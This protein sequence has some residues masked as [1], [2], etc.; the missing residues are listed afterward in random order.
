MFISLATTA[1]WK[2]VT[3]YDVLPEDCRFAVGNNDVG[4][5]PGLHVLQH[6]GQVFTI[7]RVSTARRNP[8]AASMIRRSSTAPT[9]SR[10][11]R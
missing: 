4:D 3:V 6:E 7:M 2:T 8:A 11:A 1:Q 5:P 10:P 9:S